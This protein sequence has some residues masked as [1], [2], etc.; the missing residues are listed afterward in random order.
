[1]GD[2]L[3]ASPSRVAEP[4][5]SSRGTRQLFDLHELRSRHWRDHELRNALAAR[6][7][8]AFLPQVDDDDA[9]FAAIVAVDRSGTVQ[10]RDPDAQR[11]SAARSHLPF[12]PRRY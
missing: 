4:A 7:L 10:A 1:M 8:D 9:D 6:Q 5:G 11:Q 12:V 3:L 2:G